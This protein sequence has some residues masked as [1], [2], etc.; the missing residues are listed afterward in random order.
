M[1]KDEGGNNG[2]AD[3][4]SDMSLMSLPSDLSHD[5]DDGARPKK[6]SFL[7]YS[8]EKNMDSGSQ[9]YSDTGLQLN[10]EMTDSSTIMQ[11]TQVSNQ[12][13]HFSY[14]QVWSEKHA[15]VFPE[16]QAVDQI[17][18]AYKTNKN[19]NTPD[20]S[21]L[22]FVKKVY[23]HS[24]YSSA[25][26]LSSNPQ[27]ENI[28]NS[29][30]SGNSLDTLMGQNIKTVELFQEEVHG[31]VNKRD[32][33]FLSSQ[34]RDLAH[35][36]YPRAN[37][38]STNP[39]QEMIVN[40]YDSCN[41]VDIFLGKKAKTMEPFHEE[42][43]KSSALCV[44]KEED[45]FHTRPPLM[46]SSVQANRGIVLQNII[47]H[48]DILRSKTKLVDVRGI[49][50]IIPGS[51]ENT[52]QIDTKDVSNKENEIDVFASKIAAFNITPAENKP[53]VNKFSAFGSN[54]LYLSKERGFQMSA[55]KGITVENQLDDK[56]ESYTPFCNINMMEHT[57]SLDNILHVK[58]KIQ[59]DDNIS[60]LKSVGVNTST[61]KDVKSPTRKGITPQNQILEPLADRYASLSK[62]NARENA[63]LLDDAI[64]VKQTHQMG[65]VCCQSGFLNKPGSKTVLEYL[66]ES[67][68]EPSKIFT[69]ENNSVEN[70]V[71]LHES[72]KMRQ[73]SQS[74]RNFELV[75]KQALISTQRQDNY[76]TVN[77]KSYRVQK[78]LGKGGSSRVLEVS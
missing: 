29:Y 18:E 69:Q 71:A 20:K 41:N 9:L 49:P 70:S 32:K 31:C 47:N 13:Q 58:R 14:D 33:A 17:S 78:F 39:Q 60:E 57:P 15:D 34:N 73:P 23:T 50:K 6:N 48:K 66:A 72:P 10:F 22:S 53:S 61:E 65:K 62:L 36:E 45:K 46:C 64:P 16:S 51:D 8:D 25:G 35:N 55:G 21:C 26:S 76:I 7:H 3:Y 42:V 1:A 68:K 59:E 12:L 43:H 24:E 30:D 19:V 2:N 52:K 28:G 77:G 74:N 56:V 38:S 27:K 37:C 11:E 5:G 4:D 40:V 44:K 63:T 75:Y 67:K 54:P